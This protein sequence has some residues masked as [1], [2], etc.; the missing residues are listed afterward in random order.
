MPSA[1]CSITN[2]ELSASTSNSNH[3]RPSSSRLKADTQ[4]RIHIP[5]LRPFVHSPLPKKGVHRFTQSF[6][7]SRSGFSP[8]HDET[9]EKDFKRPPSIV[10]KLDAKVRDARQEE[11]THHRDHSPTNSTRTVSC[12]IMETSSVFDPPL[13]ATA[14]MQR[15]TNDEA[16]EPTHLTPP[17]TPDSCSICQN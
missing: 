16:S 6:A 1:T 9:I 5:S 8:P 7:T 10:S 17:S 15:K 14:S 11:S 13:N 12:Q 4:D 3:G 2:L